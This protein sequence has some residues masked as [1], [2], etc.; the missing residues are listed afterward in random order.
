LN[1]KCENGVTFPTPDYPGDF[2]TRKFSARQL[3]LYQVMEVRGWFRRC[4]ADFPERLDGT[5]NPDSSFLC[6]SD[7]MASWF[8]KWFSQFKE[9]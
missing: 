2:H 8:E 5:P 6:D 7:G 3:G 1:T 9:A 4:V